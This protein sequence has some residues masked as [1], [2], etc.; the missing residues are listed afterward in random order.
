DTYRIN[1]D[2][3]KTMPFSEFI[4]KSSI[5][6]YLSDKGDIGRVLPLYWDHSG[7]DYLMQY[8]IESVGGAGSNQ[9]KTYQK[10]IGAEHTV[11]FNPTGLIND[12]IASLVNAKY[13]ITPV[14]PDDYSRYP[15]QTQNLIKSLRNFI[16]SDSLKQRIA[17]IENYNIYRND[18]SLER[19]SMIY[20]VKGIESDEEAIT[21]LKNSLFCVSDSAIVDGDLN[22][23]E[24][25]EGKIDVKKYTPN[26]IELNVNTTKRGLLLILNG[27]YP[28]WKAQIDGK[29]VKL[30]RAD[31]SFQGIDMKPGEHIVKIYFKSKAEHIGFIISLLTLIFVFATIIFEIRMKK[32]VRR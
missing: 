16:D 4:A 6:S 2:Y 5:V 31:Y 9:L 32:S 7:D 27:Y 28:A 25:G 15:V 19:F 14:L 8:Q 17:T 13:I 20:N 11:M 29:P 24:D 26:Y 22:I 18:R 1:K 23:K 3:I 10:L 30:Y 12:N 21:I